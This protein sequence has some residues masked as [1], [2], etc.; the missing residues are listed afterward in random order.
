MWLAEPVFEVCGEAVLTWATGKARA[1]LQGGERREAT[2]GN[3]EDHGVLFSGNLFAGSCQ[4]RVAYGDKQEPG[5]RFLSG[6]DL[7]ERG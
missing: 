2:Y 4:V 7:G 1:E 3:D 5:G 6:G